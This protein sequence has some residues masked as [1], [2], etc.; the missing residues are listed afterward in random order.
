[1][2]TETVGYDW[3]IDTVAGAVIIAIAILAWA[4][5]AIVNRYLTHKEIMAGRAQV[6]PDCH[7]LYDYAD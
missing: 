3:R 7:E 6:C 5:Y 1:M 2:M 4:A